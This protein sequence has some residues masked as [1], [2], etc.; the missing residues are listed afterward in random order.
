MSVRRFLKR[1]AFFDAVAHAV[2]AH[3]IIT[4]LCD[5]EYSKIEDDFVL[6]AR[7]T[8]S[9]EFDKLN[10]ILLQDFPKD[11]ESILDYQNYVRKHFGVGIE[12]YN[13]IEPTPTKL[14]VVNGDIPMIEPFFLKKEE[15]MMITGHASVALFLLMEMDSFDVSDSKEVETRSLEA[16][17]SILAILLQELLLHAPLI[18]ACEE[19]VMEKHELAIPFHVHAS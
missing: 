4:F 12:Q 10:E 9:D 7:D 5:V 11:D 3:S 6:A 16:A 17:S 8:L 19:Y 15:V 1:E 18:P 13:I 2:Y 14:R